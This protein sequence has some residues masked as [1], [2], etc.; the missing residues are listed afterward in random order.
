M[1]FKSKKAVNILVTQTPGT[2]FERDMA[3][4][5]ATAKTL[6]RLRNSGA[7][8]SVRLHANLDDEEIRR[9]VARYRGVTA[10]FVLAEDDSTPEQRKDFVARWKAAGGRES[11]GLE[12]SAARISI[13]PLLVQRYE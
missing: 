8:V 10:N 7:E 6:E 1:R 9:A 13:E 4:R 2:S 12:V 5:D 3:E 11:D